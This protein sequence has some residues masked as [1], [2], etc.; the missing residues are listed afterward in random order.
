MQSRDCLWQAYEQKKLYLKSHRGDLISEIQ[1]ICN[2]VES[3]MVVEE[4][5]KSSQQVFIIDGLD[6]ANCAAKVESLINKLE[7]VND[8][9]LNFMQK[10]IYI[11]GS[12]KFTA[13]EIQEVARRV[14]SEVVVSI[15]NTKKEEII[16]KKGNF[17]PLVFY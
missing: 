2:G 1:S 10:K 6:C 7:G 9:S 14:E 5:L 13:S 4:V 11:H 12:K 15:E 17:I 8:A 16:E 3:G